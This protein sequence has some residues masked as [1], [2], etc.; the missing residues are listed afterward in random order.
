MNPYINIHTHQHNIDKDFIEIINIDTEESL[1]VDV[2]FLYSVGIHPWN[3]KHGQRITNDGWH[4]LADTK[5]MA[6]GDCCI[7][8]AC[9]SDLEQQKY[10]FLK[11]I[12]ISEQYRKPMI[13]HAV[14]AYSDIISIRKES[15]AK[16][17]W[18]I[19][20]F[21]GNEQTCEQLLRHDEI[22]LSLGDVLYRNEKRA[23]G[24]LKLIT[25]DRLFLETDVSE[26]S[27]AEVYEKASL[28]SGRSLD[29]L[30]SDIFNNFVKIFGK[31]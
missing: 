15:K 18:I 26:R 23:T 1:N 9:V 17:P 29:E 10:L 21:Q 31:I 25:S 13:I 5:L 14:R 30:R 22:Y 11:Q 20:E 24:L 7:D 2:P 27:I 12:E 6:I 8:S 3:V 28:L 19:H 16:M 4:N